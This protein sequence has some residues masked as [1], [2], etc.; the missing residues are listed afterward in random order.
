M[1]QMRVRILPLMEIICY[2]R[3]QKSSSCNSLLKKRAKPCCWC[4]C[5][6][7]HYQWEGKYFLAWRGVFS[8]I[9]ACCP[10]IHCHTHRKYH[11]SSL[12]ATLPESVCVC[13]ND[14]HGISV[15]TV[16]LLCFQKQSTTQQRL[17]TCAKLTP[18]ECHCVC[19]KMSVT[20][21]CT[22]A[23]S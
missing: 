4:W 1:G 6:V 20:L 10:L 13:V 9:V 17:T 18:R 16:C 22:G 14:T 19:S 8:H 15:V 21:H 12:S 2:L 7:L 3:V 11:Q 5:S 23:L